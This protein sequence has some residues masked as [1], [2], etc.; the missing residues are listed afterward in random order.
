MTFAHGVAVRNDDAVAAFHKAAEVG[1]Y[2]RAVY[3]AVFMYG[4]HLPVVVEEH[5]EVVD[6]AFHVD[7]CPRSFGLVGYKHL[8]AVSVDV[9]EHVELAVVIAY[10][11]SPDALSVSLLA[12][13]QAELVA[14]TEEVVHR[15]TAEAPVDEVFRV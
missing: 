1:L 7:V 2:L 8:H 10:A 14:E 3:L 6:V 4:I 15:I 12:I 11:R 13:L 9:A 5:R